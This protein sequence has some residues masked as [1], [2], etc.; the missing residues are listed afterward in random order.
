MEIAGLSLDINPISTEKTGTLEEFMKNA[1]KYL[2]MKE[3]QGLTSDIV[4]FEMDYEQDMDMLEFWDGEAEI[5]E[6]PIYQVYEI[7]GNAIER[8]DTD[9]FTEHLKQVIESHGAEEPIVKAAEDL[10]SNPEV[11]TTTFRR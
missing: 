3:V 10:F 2:D 11:K 6:N 9:K 1:E 8:K 5:E 7:I 4:K